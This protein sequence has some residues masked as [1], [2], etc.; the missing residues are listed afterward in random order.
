ML[1]ER[2]HYTLEGAWEQNVPLSSQPLP[3]AAAA[4]AAAARALRWARQWSVPPLLLAFV[5]EKRGDLSCSFADMKW[6]IIIPCRT[7]CLFA[8]LESSGGR[9]RC[10][11]P[12]HLIFHFPW[13]TTFGT[14]QHADKDDSRLR[15]RFK[16]VGHFHF[17]SERLKQT[18]VHAVIIFL[19]NF[20]FS[21]FSVFPFISISS[22]LKSVSPLISTCSGIQQ[23]KKST[24]QD[25][26]QLKYSEKKTK[27]KTFVEGHMTP[28]KRQWPHQIAI[29]EA[30][31][32][33]IYIIAR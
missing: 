4:K 3:F 27:N 8:S 23:Q 25:R 33:R 5:H 12:Y 30:A 31:D 20:N 28:Q 21:P 16:E 2:R 13:V 15:R 14:E 24:T 17:V 9:L 29:T 22:R 18:G 19:L 32:C 7:G 11:D 6:L 26:T 1:P 10:S